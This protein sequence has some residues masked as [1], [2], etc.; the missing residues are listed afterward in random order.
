MS[1]IKEIVYQHK[2]TCNELQVAVQSFEKH[3]HIKL[4]YTMCICIGSTLSYFLWA[5]S[6]MQHD[7]D[8]NKSCMQ[9]DMDTKYTIYH[10]DQVSYDS[11][12]K[13][14]NAPILNNLSQTNEI[15]FNACYR[16]TRTSHIRNR[17]QY[18]CHEQESMR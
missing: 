15:I 16:I 18:Q 1:Y 3:P 10:C 13:L 6:C 9:H 8:T 2:L 4:P 17:R 7:M 14:I 11:Y 12:A 5:K